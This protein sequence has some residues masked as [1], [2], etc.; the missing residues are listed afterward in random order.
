MVTAL[1]IIG[2]DPKVAAGTSGFQLFFIGASSLIQAYVDGSITPVEIYWFFGLAFIPGGILTFFL[3][4][5]LGN[6]ENKYLALVVFF[7]CCLFV[8]GTIPSI[9]ITA[10]NY[11]W[12]ELLDLSIDKC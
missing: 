4:R 3:Y 12:S 7:L 1:L 10:K 2:L 9:F 11:G 5:F 8:T 6:K